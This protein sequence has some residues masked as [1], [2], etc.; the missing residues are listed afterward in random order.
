[1]CTVNN[2][3]RMYE[4]ICMYRMYEVCLFNKFKLLDLNEKFVCYI[5]KLIH[6]EAGIVNELF[7]NVSKIKRII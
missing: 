6:N 7:H 1:M 2:C 3:I 4:C 5:W